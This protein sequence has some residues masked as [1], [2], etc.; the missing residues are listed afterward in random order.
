[1][2]FDRVD[3]MK[4]MITIMTVGLVFMCGTSKV[5]AEGFL[6][7]NA[8]LLRSRP[9]PAASRSPIETNAVNTVSK[10]NDGNGHAEN[11]CN[12]NVENNIRRKVSSDRVDLLIKRSRHGIQITFAP[13]M[14]QGINHDHR[15]RMK[16]GRSEFDVPSRICSFADDSVDQTS[17]KTKQSS[18]SGESD[19][20]KRGGLFGGKWTH[21]PGLTSLALTTLDLIGVVIGCYRQRRSFV[22]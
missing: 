2:T 17:P 10:R 20:T 19:R 6:T 11:D 3:Q 1:M 22:V 4:L 16:P 8:Q 9:T 7:D 15:N 13:Q 5:R 18:V 14:D 12:Q 21:V